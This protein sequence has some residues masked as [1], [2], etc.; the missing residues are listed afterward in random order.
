[1]LTLTIVY[2]FRRAL[3]GPPRPERVGRRLGVVLVVVVPTLFLVG[4][5]GSGAL[6]RASSTNC[7]ALGSATCFRAFVWMRSVSRRKLEAEYPPTV[8]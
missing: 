8:G 6:S 7:T 1:M 5:G 4:G 3:R 2:L